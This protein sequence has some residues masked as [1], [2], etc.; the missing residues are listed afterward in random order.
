[1]SFNRC[2]Y[3][4]TSLYSSYGLACLLECAMILVQRPSTGFRAARVSL[5]PSLPVA[6]LPSVDAARLTRRD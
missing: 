4:Q 6:A 5:G 3:N 1:M 2:H